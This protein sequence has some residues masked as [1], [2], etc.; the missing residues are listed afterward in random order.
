MDREDAR[1]SMDA[2]LS[3]SSIDVKERRFPKADVLCDIIS[4]AV[5]RQAPVQ[6]ILDQQYDYFSELGARLKG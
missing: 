2:R 4:L 1:D 6:E 5:N 3:D